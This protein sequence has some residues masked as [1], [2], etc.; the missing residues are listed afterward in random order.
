MSS[1]PTSSPVSSLTAF[2][3]AFSLTRRDPSSTEKA[4]DFDAGINASS[5]WTDSL[6]TPEGAARVSVSIKDNINALSDEE[7]EVGERDEDPHPEFDELEGRS[8]RALYAFEGKPEFR[9]LTS[10]QAGDRLEVLKEE[11]GD[12]WSLVK[13]LESS[14][15]GARNEVGLLP[16][17][18][19]TVSP[20][21][22]FRCCAY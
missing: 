8:A 17:S 20:S 18:Y 16:R 11:V 13:H 15:T 14:E 22:H 5:A 4:P 21:Y 2:L 3:N 7:L 12:G 9:E 19:Y 1:G 10:V 6:S